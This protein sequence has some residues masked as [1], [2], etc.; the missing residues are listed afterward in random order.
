MGQ[1]R[2]G[3]L[4][5]VG[6]GPFSHISTA[7]R[8]GCALRYNGIASYPRS[9]IQKTT[10]CNVSRVSDCCRHRWVVHVKVIATVKH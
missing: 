8:P 2:R 10:G 6:E 3:E 9:V 7:I 1:A 5:R 4:V